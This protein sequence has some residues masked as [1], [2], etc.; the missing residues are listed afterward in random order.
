MQ[1][2][3]FEFLGQG[4]QGIIWKATYEVRDDDALR[5]TNPRTKRKPSILRSRIYLANL[6]SLK[7]L[8]R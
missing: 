2:K 1:V 5:S 3:T 4:G 8:A 7:W 6:F